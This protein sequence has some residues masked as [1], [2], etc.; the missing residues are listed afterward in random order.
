MHAAEIDCGLRS[1]FTFLF[2]HINVS[3]NTWVFI[4]QTL[5]MIRKFLPNPGL[6]TQGFLQYQSRGFICR[7]SNPVYR[8]LTSRVPPCNLQQH[9]LCK[10]H[11]YENWFR[12]IFELSLNRSLGGGIIHDR[13]HPV[14]P[15]PRNEEKVWHHKTKFTRISPSTRNTS[16]TQ[17]L[18][19]RLSGME[20]RKEST[21]IEKLEEP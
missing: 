11:S 21:R 19:R 9:S 17:V 1:F 10:F 5:P 12:L 15:V 3:I 16:R 4:D 8:S 13:F 18:L 14:H 20:V 2:I 7:I 6:I